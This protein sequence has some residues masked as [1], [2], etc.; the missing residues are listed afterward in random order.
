MRVAILDADILRD[1][2][3]P[4]YHSYGRMF[5][6]LLQRQGV[7]WTLDVF[8]VIRGEYPDS[9]YDYDAFLITGSQ[10]DAFSDTD[11]VVRLRAYVRSLYQQGKPLVGV[12]FGHQLLAHAL[13]G[14][15]GRAGQGWGL[16]VMTYPLATIPPFADGDDPVDLIVSHRDQ[17]TA[18]PP[19]AE[20]LLGNEFCPLAAFYIPRRVLAIQGHP[21]FSE[22]YARALLHYRR[23]QVPEEQLIRAEQSFTRAHDG[24]RVGGWIRAFLEQA[25]A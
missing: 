21:E 17:V 11:W 23:E 5:V 1:T 3:Q 22:A 10:Y 25:V 16:G 24:E 15:A 7:D 9:A 19:G 2:L 18:L 14:E 6:A 8:T 20:L 12:C 4:Q 13:G